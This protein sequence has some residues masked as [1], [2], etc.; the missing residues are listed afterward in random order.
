VQSGAP[1]LNTTAAMAL[2]QAPARVARFVEKLPG[3]EGS[4]LEA[5]TNYT[6]TRRIFWS[7]ITATSKWDS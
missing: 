6:K 4:V 7:F 1:I 5:R 2:T 3:Y